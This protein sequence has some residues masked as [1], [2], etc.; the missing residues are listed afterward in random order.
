M[1]NEPS[2]VSRQLSALRVG[3][4]TSDL[5]PSHGWGQHSLS[6]VKALHKAGVKLTVITSREMDRQKPIPANQSGAGASELQD[7]EIHPLLPSVTPMGRYFELKLARQFPAVSRLLQDCDV[8]HTTIEPYAPLAAWVAGKRPCFVTAHGSYSRLAEK[9]RWPFNMLYRQAFMRSKI[10]CVSRYTER[11]AH[12]A[13]PGVKTIVVNN[14]VDYERYAGKSSAI[15]YQPGTEL[16]TENSALILSVGAVKARKGTL[17]LAQAIARVR[18]R[19][20][21]VKCVIIGSLTAEP[22][23]VARVRETI[24]QPGLSN[25]VH[26]LGHVPD[27]TLLEWYSRADVFVLPSIND[28][29]KF[30]GY[31]LVYLEAS[32]AG[33]PVIGTTDCGAEDAIDDG[34][35][36]LLVPQ[37]QIAE[38][39]PEAIIRILLEP[40]LATRMGQA[41]R[42]KA[43]G[44]TW[45]HVAAQML[46]LYNE[47]VRR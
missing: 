26:L 25:H 10:I 16:K 17:E 4:I 3:L 42:E 20:P 33:L 43:A 6:L 44:Q 29:W 45:D 11:V 23:Y 39:L 34:V 1:V 21:D 31:G 47:G 22:E 35:T 14:G 41:G 28:E 8:I 15:N 27:E 32:A 37:T 38:R 5:S 13:L 18:E 19:I 2:A 36:G 9:R 30:E 40:E 24:Q 12:K 46:A 7:V